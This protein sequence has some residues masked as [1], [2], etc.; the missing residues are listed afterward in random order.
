MLKNNEK[1]KQVRV[2]PFETSEKH[3]SNRDVFFVV[4]Y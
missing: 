2:I 4:T 3:I 1:R